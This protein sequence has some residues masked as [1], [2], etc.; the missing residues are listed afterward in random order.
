MEYLI[1]PG[2]GIMGGCDNPING[3]APDCGGCYSQC[4]LLAIRCIWP[5]VPGQIPTE[6]PPFDE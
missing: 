4:Q 1:E 2:E 5:S 3:L 6:F